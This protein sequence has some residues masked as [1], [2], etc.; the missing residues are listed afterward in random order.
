MPIRRRYANSSQPVQYQRQVTSPSQPVVRPATPPAATP[1]DRATVA[2]SEPGGA[3]QG[4]QGLINGF[5][6][7]AGGSNL[8]ELLKASKGVQ[9]TPEE[10]AQV[11]QAAGVMQRLAGADGLWNRGDLQNNVSQ[12]ERSGDLGRA[13]SSEISRRWGQELSQRGIIGRALVNGHMRN[14]YDK[15]QS[16]GM[17]Q[18]RG[19]ARQELSKGLDGAGTKDSAGH[20]ADKTTPEGL[21]KSGE[22]ISRAEMEQMQKTM[23]MLKQ[24]SAQQGLPEVSFPNGVPAQFLKDVAEGK[25]PQQALKDAGALLKLKNGQTLEMNKLPNMGGDKAAEAANKAIQQVGDVFKGFFGGKGSEAA[26]ENKAAEGSL[27][28]AGKSGPEVSK[29]ET[30]QN[31][32]T[33]DPGAA[34]RTPEVSQPEGPAEGGPTEAA[35]EGAPAEASTEGDPSEPPPPPAGGE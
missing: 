6:S 3:S 24:K 18:A 9:L 11:Q 25:S 4:V 15:Y 20:Q 27:E 29:S 5:G 22:P 14:N 30:S 10:R 23:D 33:K 17:N 21:K 2:P 16:Q 19:M 1:G 13:V 8:G 7:W 32:D 31:P 34:E 35:N 12:L 26:T 28:G